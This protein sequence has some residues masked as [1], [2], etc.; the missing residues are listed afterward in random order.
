MLSHGVVNDVFT[1]LSGLAWEKNIS[2]TECSLRKN[3]NHLFSSM[4]V[5]CCS[6]KVLPSGESVCGRT[7]STHVLILVGLVRVWVLT[8]LCMLQLSY[9]GTCFNYS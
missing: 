6:I 3:C 1:L 5:Y 2:E 4:I 9:N 8:F 7:A